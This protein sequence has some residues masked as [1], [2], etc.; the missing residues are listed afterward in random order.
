MAT[1]PPGSDVPPPDADDVS[2]SG[3]EPRR[4]RW[5]FSA[6]EAAHV[7]FA[8]PRDGQTLPINQYVLA[9]ERWAIAIR[10]REAGVIDE[11]ERAAL[12]GR[13]DIVA[14]LT[15]VPTPKPSAFVQWLQRSAE[16]IQSIRRR[17]PPPMP[18]P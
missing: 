3:S 7:P 11:A 10:R 6:P 9:V 16:R 17:P 18:Q 14:L 15:H 8:A 12:E 2:A 5:T 13:P 4:L 1:N